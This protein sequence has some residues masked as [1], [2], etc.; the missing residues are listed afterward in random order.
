MNG[1][2]AGLFIIRFFVGFVLVWQGGNK[3]FGGMDAVTGMV[4]GLGF[5][6][7]AFFAWV[8]G[9]VEFFGGLILIVGSG[10][11]VASVLILIAMLVAFFGVHKGSF[12]L[13]GI[14]PFLIIGSMLG[15][16]FTGAGKWNIC[17][18]L[19]LKGHAWMCG[20]AD[21]VCCAKEGCAEGGCSGSC[22]SM[23]AKEVKDEC[24]GGHDHK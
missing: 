12:A 15:F 1:R 3:L 11:R 14:A 20:C 17:R 19:G 16:I 7:P 4:A 6:A 10:I 18:V 2:S 8:L 13:G 5:P 22:G 24:C 21:E 23:K 9:L